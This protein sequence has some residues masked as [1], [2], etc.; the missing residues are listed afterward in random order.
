MSA[1]C[2]CT[3]DEPICIYYHGEAIVVIIQLI[4]YS[5]VVL[6]CMKF[7]H[8]V[9]VSACPS[10]VTPAVCSDGCLG[11]VFVGWREI[12]MCGW[13]FHQQVLMETSVIRGYFT[14]SIGH[15]SCLYRARCQVEADVELIRDQ[16]QPL[17]THWS[18]YLDH[19]STEGDKK[20]DSTSWTCDQY[21]IQIEILNYNKCNIYYGCEQILNKSIFNLEEKKKA[22]NVGVYNFCIEQLGFGAVNDTDPIVSN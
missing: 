22:T 12:P 1:D 7:Q 19:N 2:W 9:L 20:A 13:G 21:H 3:E 6:V 16:D 5:W 17:G 10:S 15:H 18:L 8:W 11:Q 4:N 14:D